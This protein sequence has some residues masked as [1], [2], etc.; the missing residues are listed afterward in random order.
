MRL[1]DTRGVLVYRNVSRFL[2]KWESESRSQIQFKAKQFFK[3]Y[4]V[5]HI[6]YEEF[7]VYGTRLKVDLM[8]M[9]RKIAIEVQGNQHNNYSKFFHGSRVAYWNS[10]RRDDIKANWVESNKFKF[11]ELTTE[12]IELLSYDFMLE[13]F[14]VYL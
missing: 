12:D 1:L 4:W 7:P 11:I 9:T 6:V 10:I 13:K 2:I 3:K 5:N 14:Q 8:N